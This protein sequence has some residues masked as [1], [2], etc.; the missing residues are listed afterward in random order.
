[1]TQASAYEKQGRATITCLVTK[2]R[3][4]KHVKSRMPPTKNARGGAQ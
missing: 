3:G 4:Y 2:L 1:M